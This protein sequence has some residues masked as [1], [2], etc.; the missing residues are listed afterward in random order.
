MF[1]VVSI[2]LLL[3][4]VLLQ[5]YKSHTIAG[6]VTHLLIANVKALNAYCWGVSNI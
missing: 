4:H 2:H 1:Q 3:L 6:I 5:W